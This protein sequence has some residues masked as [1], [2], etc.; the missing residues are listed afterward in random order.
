MPSDYVIKNF[1]DI[2]PSGADGIEGRFSR[3]FLDS[4]ELGMS[5]W[6]Y[7][8]GR[9]HPATATRSKRRSTQS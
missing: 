4:S 8:P 6:R 5:R 2:D 1:E 3:K 7:E 9:R